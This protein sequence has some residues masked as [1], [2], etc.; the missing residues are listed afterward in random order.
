MFVYRGSNVISIQEVELWYIPD[1]YKI[2][3]LLQQWFEGTGEGLTM[4]WSWGK[5]HIVKKFNLRSGKQDLTLLFR[6]FFSLLC[7]RNIWQWKIYW[8]ELDHK[9][10]DLS[11]RFKKFVKIRLRSKLSLGLIYGLSFRIQAAS[12]FPQS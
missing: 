4:R 8:E 12:Y 2:T 3:I 7:G 6:W 9:M 11:P 5:E 1:K 10:K